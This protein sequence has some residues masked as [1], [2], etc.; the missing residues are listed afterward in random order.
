MVIFVAPD[1]ADKSFKALEKGILSC[2]VNQ[3]P[4][5]RSIP[6]VN[7]SLCKFNHKLASI[8]PRLNFSFRMIKEACF[9]E[10]QSQESLS[11]RGKHL[12]VRIL[13][14]CY[15]GRACAPSCVPGTGFVADLVLWGIISSSYHKNH[16]D[17]QPFFSRRNMS[18]KAQQR[19][20]FKI[21][22]DKH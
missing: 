12:R 17:H 6:H 4:C 10:V 2:L 1:T 14:Q 20:F 15:F 13:C 9:R 22:P 5:V 18:V 19:C 3:L 7:H 11:A 21:H 16:N 8:L